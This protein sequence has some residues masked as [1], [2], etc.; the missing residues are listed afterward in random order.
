MSEDAILSKP[1]PYGVE[2]SKGWKRMAGRQGERGISQGPGA[3]D[4][5]SKYCHI[6]AK[7]KSKHTKCELVF[8]IFKK[9]CL[10]RQVERTLYLTVWY[11]DL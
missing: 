9:I 10:S 3:I 4:Q 6:P 5:L 8:N 1:G 2:Q 7:S 11:L